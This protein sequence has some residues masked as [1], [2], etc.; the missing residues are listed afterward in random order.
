MNEISKHI[1]P[2]ANRTLA[3]VSQ[4]FWTGNVPSPLLRTMANMRANM[5]TVLWFGSEDRTF[6]LR[7]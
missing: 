3:M 4:Q 6:P 1:R 7:F 5:G 2:L